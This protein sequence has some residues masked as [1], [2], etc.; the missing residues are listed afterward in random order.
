[1]SDQLDSLFAHVRGV[2]PPAAFATADQ[3]RRRGKQRTHRK[4]LAVGSSV[5]AVTSAATGLG[6]GWAVLRPDGDGPP[7]G[8]TSTATAPATASPTP[9]HAVGGIRLQ[10][11]DLGP[12][13]WRPVGAEQ[14]Q[15]KDRWFWGFW[16]DVCPTYRS[17]RFPSLPHRVSVETVAF[18]DGGGTGAEPSGDVNS[19]FQIVERYAEGWG[20]ASLADVRAVIGLCGAAAPPPGEAPQRY[21]IVGTGFAG[22][23]SLLVKGESWSFGA[24]GTPEPDPNSNYIAVVR[25]G[26]LV[27]TVRAYPGDPDRVR[28]LA[29]RAATRLG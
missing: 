15:N 2:Q 24:G 5:F 23:E 27:T 25:V 26:D 11:S 1:M 12:G 21:T 8:S 4:A 22:D 29:E 28:T 9:T 14:L 20:D 19:V 7:A 3:V 16:A 17:D 10:P 18:R 6:M 13:E